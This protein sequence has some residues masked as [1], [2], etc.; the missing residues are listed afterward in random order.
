MFIGCN[1]TDNDR[2]IEDEL[3]NDEKAKDLLTQ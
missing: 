1:G 2:L 3:G